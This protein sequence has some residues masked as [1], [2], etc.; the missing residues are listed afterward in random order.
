MNRLLGGAALVAVAIGTS[1]AQRG[2]EAQRGGRAAPPPVNA[3]EKA[4]VRAKTP[5][6]SAQAAQ[7]QAIRLQL[8]QEYNRKVKNQ[9]GLNQ[10]Q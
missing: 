4:P 3:Q 2:A 5:A 6:E 8:R 1:G 9:L 7:N 10:T